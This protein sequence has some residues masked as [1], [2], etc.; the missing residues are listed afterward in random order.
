M[1]VKQAGSRP[2]P[3]SYCHC[4]VPHDGGP[5]LKGLSACSGIYIPM[6]VL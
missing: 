2:A 6:A 4:A 3:A 5:Q 1:C